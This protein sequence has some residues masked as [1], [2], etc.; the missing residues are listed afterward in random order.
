MIPKTIDRDQ[1]A[2][3]ELQSPHNSVRVQ[4]MAILFRRKEESKS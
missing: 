1:V 3:K 2:L 4:L